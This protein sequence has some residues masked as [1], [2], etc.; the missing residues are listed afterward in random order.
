MKQENETKVEEITNL[1]TALRRSQSMIGKMCGEGRPPRMSIPVR[2][3]DDED[4]FICETINSAIDVLTH[5][6]SPIHATKAS[7]EKKESKGLE[8]VP[9]EPTKEMVAVYL[10]AARSMVR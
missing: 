9:I 2:P 7:N 10:A 8:L 1:I 5:I 6:K 4:V 3:L